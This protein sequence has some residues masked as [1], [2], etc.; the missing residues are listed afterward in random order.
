MAVHI[1]HIKPSEIEAV[2]G[3]IEALG[4]RHRISPLASGDVMRLGAAAL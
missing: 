2:M 3:Q 4:S 1:T